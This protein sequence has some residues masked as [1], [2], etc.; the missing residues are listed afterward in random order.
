MTPEQAYPHMPDYDERIKQTFASGD[1]V[2]VGPAY[3]QGG[4]YANDGSEAEYMTVV[5][6]LPGTTDYYLARGYVRADLASTAM[7][8]LLC[9]AARLDLVEKAQRKTQRLGKIVC[10]ECGGTDANPKIRECSGVIHD[11]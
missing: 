5:G 6:V 7:W 9:S 8:D 2:R 3:Q 4:W 10:A 11:Q 1:I